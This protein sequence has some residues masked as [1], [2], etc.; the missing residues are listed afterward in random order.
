LVI[1]TKVD[2]HEKLYHHGYT[3]F[4]K[5]VL[6]ASK[7]ERFIYSD[8]MHTK[9]Y[10]NWATVDAQKFTAYRLTINLSGE[11]SSVRVDFFILT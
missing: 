3:Q 2:K 11:L 6:P 5:Y 1:L 4:H 9:V 10:C 8:I 7:R